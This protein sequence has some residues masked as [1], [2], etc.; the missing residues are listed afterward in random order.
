MTV[1]PNPAPEEARR[2]LVE[3]I[4]ADQAFAEQLIADPA[5]A[6]AGAGL[7]PLV[8]APEEREEVQG[9]A[10]AMCM[11]NGHSVTCSM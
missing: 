1:N 8:G 4:R 6:L 3:R 7:A 9:Y 2:A 5:E 11:P 10:A